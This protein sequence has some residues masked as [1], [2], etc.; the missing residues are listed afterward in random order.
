MDSLDS[1]VAFLC[2]IVFGSEDVGVGVGGSVVGAV[3]VV[4]GGAT[5]GGGV[6]VGAKV[7]GAAVVVG[8]SNS[9]HLATFER[10][11]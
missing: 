10:F 9:I 3:R 2:R 7:G 5:V 8:C 4:G 6:G 11:S 1:R